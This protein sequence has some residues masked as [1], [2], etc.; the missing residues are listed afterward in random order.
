MEPEI[1]FKQWLIDHEI[2][3]DYFEDGN[4]RVDDYLLRNYESEL[5]KLFPEIQ[6]IWEIEPNHRCKDI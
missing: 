6:F 5:K 4:V 1:T 3:F 2:D